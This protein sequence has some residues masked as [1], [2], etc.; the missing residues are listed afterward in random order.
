MHK[1]QRIGRIDGLA[2]RSRLKRWNAAG[3]LLCV[4]VCI[5]LCIGFSGLLL[6]FWFIASAAFINVYVS[7][8]GWRNY[9]RLCAAPLGLLLLG[10]IA[11]AA[12]LSI[13]GG[14]SFGLSRA[15]LSQALQVTLRAFACISLFFVLILST[16]VHELIHALRRLRVP[17]LI[18]SLMFLIYRY[19]FILSRSYYIMH[20]AALSRLGFIDYPISLRTFAASISRL[21]L[22]ALKKSSQYYDAMLSRGYEG[23][24]LFYLEERGISRVQLL[25]SVLYV[26]CSLWI[27]V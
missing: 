24:V 12:E 18:C 25:S 1:E 8:A 2:N 26:L 17:G 6:S 20:D 22:I 7:T 4:L 23:E 3:K 10:F 5:L 19:I 11:I 15:S 16:P 21:F 14:V 9:R 27:A 13:S